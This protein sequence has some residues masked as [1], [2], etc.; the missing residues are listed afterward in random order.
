M[1]LFS[2]N[3]NYFDIFNR[4]SSKS[5]KYNYQEVYN[6]W[7]RYREVILIKII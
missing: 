1:A 5:S 2:M 4:W 6:H 7:S 3:E